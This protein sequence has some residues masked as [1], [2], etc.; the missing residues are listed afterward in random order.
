MEQ[1]DNPDYAIEAPKQSPDFLKIREI[2]GKKSVFILPSGEKELI[3]TLAM[4]WDERPLSISIVESPDFHFHLFKDGRIR[5]FVDPDNLGECF[6][7]Q[8]LSQVS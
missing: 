3:V 5:V 1:S 6:A 7:R 8:L 4:T 2:L